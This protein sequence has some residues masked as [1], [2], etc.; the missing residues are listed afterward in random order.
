[1]ELRQLRHFAAVAQHGNFTRAA[2]VLNLTQ[3]ALSRQVKNLEDELGLTLIKRSENGV[4]LTPAGRLFW[5]EAGELIS[6]LDQAA[7]RV[8]RQCGTDR[9]K[10][11]YFPPFVAGVMPRLLSRFKT[12]V[13]G[14]APE[15]L[16]L[17]IQEIISRANT[18]K[19]HVAFLPSD[20]ES[21][22]PNFQ[23]NSFRTIPSTLI[24]SKHHPLAKLRKISP[25]VL[26]DYPVHGLG[27]LAF[28]EYA[29]RLRA[30]LR[31]YRLKPTFEDQT[32]DGVSTLFA[33]LEAHN[34]LAVLCEG[35]SNMMPATLVS[36][37]FDP[38]LPPMNVGIGL[39]KT[40]ANEQ[41]ES[42]LKLAFEAVRET[43]LDRPRN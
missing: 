17:T 34:G 14:A 15:L 9:I 33:A 42:F 43:D 18:G 27:H 41:A 5:E 12:T 36:R 28:P 37:P 26:K 13:G 21:S 4:T 32:S 38:E 25:T 6:Q 20:L 19:L 16:E 22:V 7:Q 8:K 11:G 24:M 35:V 23:W 2:K 3:P 10:V 40:P 1:M 39:P 30:M 31:P 29:P